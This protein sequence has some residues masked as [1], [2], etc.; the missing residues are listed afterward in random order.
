MA[1][2][3]APR[4]SQLR[5]GALGTTEEVERLLRIVGVRWEALIQRLGAVDDWCTRDVE[6][7]LCALMLGFDRP[8][9]SVGAA[10]ATIACDRLAITLTPT[11]RGE[12]LIDEFF[13]KAKP[14]STGGKYRRAGSSQRVWVGHRLK[15]L[16]WAGARI[17]FNPSNVTSAGAETVADI[18]AASRNVCITRTDVA[19]DLPTSL[20]G[21][22]AIGTRQRKA[23]A[24]WN[25]SQIETI[26]VGSDKAKLSFAIYDRK[27]K[28]LHERHDSARVVRPIEG[29]DTRFEVRLKKRRLRPAQFPTIDNPFRELRLLWLDGDGLSYLD[30]I[31]LRLAQVVGFPLVE[32]QL[33]PKRRERLRERF[34]AAAAKVGV[35]HP[36]DVFESSWRTEADRVL[37]MLGVG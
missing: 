8:V 13:A 29:D 6:E 15:W 4:L 32:R 21:V 36:R 24:V 37:S 16:G 23:T 1:G 11:S 9:P 26:Y 10:P 34:L 3:S 22:Q 12:A 2:L 20:V 14:L 28:L 19:V 27:S 35:P 30:R 17:D 31:V 33:P 7:L 5:S 18:V 25:G